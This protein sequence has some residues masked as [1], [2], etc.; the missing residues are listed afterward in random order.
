MS[1]TEYKH[2]LSF[3]ELQQEDAWQDV[4]ITARVHVSRSL[5]GR[6]L[7]EVGDPAMDGEVEDDNGGTWRRREDPRNVANAVLDGGMSL[8]SE[9]DDV[10]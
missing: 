4:P 9:L 3:R 8:G 10:G 2:G 1:W 7:S 6:K 5:E